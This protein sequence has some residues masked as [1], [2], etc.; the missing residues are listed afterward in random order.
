MGD[1]C[2]RKLSNRNIRLSIPTNEK[3]CASMLTTIEEIYWFNVFVLAPI[4]NTRH[5][6]RGLFGHCLACPRERFARTEENPTSSTS[7]STCYSKNDKG[8]RSLG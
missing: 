5:H 4:E 2:A 3:G 1:V 7:K 8:G 6:R